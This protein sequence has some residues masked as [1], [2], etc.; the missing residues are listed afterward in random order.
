MTFGQLRPSHDSRPMEANEKRSE[1]EPVA[2]AASPAP[3][4]GRRDRLVRGGLVMTFVSLVQRLSGFVAH[5]GLG[6][7]LV[8]EDF[9]LYAIA[10]GL[11]S[12]GSAV[13]SALQP[14]LIGHLENNPAAFARTYRTTL[15][16]LWLLV[17]VGVAASPLI[18]RTLDA[19]GLRSLLIILLLSTPLQVYAGFGMARISHSMEF[20]SVGKT[21]T[22]V[23]IGRHL[24]TV[25]FAFG[26]LGAMSFALG[27]IAA[28]TI[29]LAVLRR[30]TTLSVTPGLLSTATIVDIKGSWGRF[31]SGV[32]RRWIWLS[33]ISLTMATSGQFTAASLW[34]PQ[35]VVGLYYFAFGL[36]GAFWLP[37]SLAVNTVLVPGFV[38]LKSTEE[39]RERFVETIGILSVMGVLLFN[40][41]AVTI[42]PMTHVLWD[43]KWDAAFPALLIFALVAPLQFIHP[44]I[45]AIARGTDQWNLYFIDIMA[46]AVFTIGAAGL[47]AYLGGLTTIVWLVVWAEVAVTYAGLL[48]M[49][50]TFGAS[51]LRAL[52]AASLPWL[53]GLAGLFVSHLVLPLDDPDLLRSIWRFGVFTALTVAL[54]VVPWRGPL[55]GLAQSLARRRASA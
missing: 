23:A 39:R 34:A 14:V 3:G 4:S 17:A 1:V 35:D 18:E 25:L 36:T 29:E 15:A 48:W 53:A 19:P 5:W 12:I 26:G 44:V 11:T 30:F 49:S 47:G 55:L 41:V 46:T 50:R 54:V 32:D 21:M 7:L 16:S 38:A 43:G 9:G 2:V 33:A 42:V 40:T 28:T 31:V 52:G 24:V 10:L 27:Q 22:A 20:G 45:H 6:L 13:R 37:L 8:E 51:L